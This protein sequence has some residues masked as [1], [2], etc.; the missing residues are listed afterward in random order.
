MATNSAVRSQVIANDSMGTVVEVLE[1][2]LVLEATVQGFL[3][4]SRL[5]IKPVYDLSEFLGE[6]LDCRPIGFDHQGRV[7]LSRREILEEES[8]D[9]FERLLARVEPGEVLDGRVVKVT[10]C[11]AFVAID[12]SEC[13]V[14]IPGLEWAGIRPSDA[15]SLADQVR[16]KVLEVDRNRRHLFL[17]LV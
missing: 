14:Q 8:Q 10:D 3:P 6:T 7:I 16:V 5:D 9:A 15:V 4:A 17:A 1:D 2:G 11:G 13:F 12:E